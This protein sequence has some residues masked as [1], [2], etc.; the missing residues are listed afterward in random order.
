MSVARMAALIGCAFLGAMPALSS[1]KAE[2]EVLDKYTRTETFE[3][4]INIQRIQSSRILNRHQI[5]FEMAGGDAY[6]NEPESC[7]GL[8]KSL[9][10]GYDATTGDLCTTTIVRLIDAGSP[11]GDRGSCGLAKFQKLEEKPAP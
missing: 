10:L 9:A 2:S 6:L 1:D 3:N 7:P 5:L 4:C 11:A 8:N